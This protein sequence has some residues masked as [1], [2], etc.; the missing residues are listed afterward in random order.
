LNSKK[1]IINKINQLLCGPSTSKYLIEKNLLR[2]KKL[3]I[4]N[5]ID[6]ISKI[7]EN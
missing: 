4:K 3:I 6:D 5:I 1:K 7:D 2:E